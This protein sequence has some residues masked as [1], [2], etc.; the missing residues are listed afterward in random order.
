MNQPAAEPRPAGP[1]EEHPA[2]ARW[3]TYAASAITV[4]LAAAALLGW[5]IDSPTLRSLIAGLWQM[6]PFTAACLII[7]G[8]ALGAIHYGVWRAGEG[9]SWVLLAGQVMALVVAVVGAVMLAEYIFGADLLLDRIFFPTAIQSTARFHPGRSSAASSVAFIFAGVSLFLLGQSGTRARQAAQLTILPSGLIGF[10]GGVGYLFGSQEFTELTGRTPLSLNTAFALIFLAVGVLATFPHVGVMAVMTAQD[11]GGRL[12]RRLVPVAIGVPIILQWLMER[13]IS[14][15][16]YSVTYGIALV[17]A[18]LVIVFTAVVWRI[19]YAL[20]RVDRVRTAFEVERARLLEDEHR[21]REEEREYRELAESRARREAALR[22]ELEEVTESRARLVRGFSHDLKNPLGA[23]DGHA[24]LLESGIFGALEP[25]QQESVQRIRGALHAALELIDDLV[26][27]AR[28]EAGQLTIELAPIDPRSL[29]AEVAEEHR[30]HA[31][32]SGLGFEVEVPEVLPSIVSDASRVRQILGNLLSNAIK[33][34]PAGGRVT[35][36]VASC[37]TG[38]G[39]ARGRWLCL[40]VRDTGPGIPKEKQHKLFQEFVRLATRGEPGVGLGLAISQRIARLLGGELT[41]ESESGQGSTF[42]LWLPLAS[43][44]AGVG[45]RDG[46]EPEA[47]EGE[48]FHQLALE[49][50]RLQ[51]IVEHIPVGVTLAEAPSGRIVLTNPALEQILRRPA[52]ISPNVAAYGERPGYHADGRRYEAEEWPLARALLHG[53]QVR[54]EECHYRLGDGTMT[55]IRI[56]AAPIRDLSGEIVGAVESIVDF[57]AE[58]R[59]VEEQRFLSEAS[60]ILGSSLDTQTMLAG[61]AQ[62]AVKS[63]AEVC[64]I[65]LRDEA[66]GTLRLGAAA[67]RDPALAPLIARLREHPAGHANQE[68]SDAL[69]AGRPRLVA[70]V[71]DDWLSSAAVDE[72]Q[73]QLYREF[74]AKSM[75]LAPLIARGRSLGT[76]TFVRNSPGTHYTEDDLALFAEAS[77]RAA[78]AIDNARLYEAALVASQTKS[79]FLAVMSHELR[80]PLN[81]IVGY[82]DLLLLG[83]PKPLP[84]EDREAVYRITASA[85]RLKEQIDEIL[86][87]SRIEADREEVHLEEVEIGALVREVAGAVAP[88]IREKGLSLA[89]VTPEQ[90]TRI[91]TDPGELRQ[92][93]RNILSNAIKFTSRGEIRVEAAR[94]GDD[95]VIQI[96]DTGIGIAPEFRERVF[97]P[98]WQVERGMTRE[99]SGTGLGLSVSRRLARMLGGDITF[100]SEPG[101]GTTFMVR[102]PGI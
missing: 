56:D 102:L 50:A 24:A 20:S 60:A 51:V 85:Q 5:I 68:I 59:A 46:G 101:K 6:T 38:P 62:A 37:E 29:A 35:L 26:E 45:G 69:E 48:L 32:T 3:V 65:Y 49:R 84:E 76:A 73:F 1:A 40:A 95:V 64:V 57:T 90:A 87:F 30:A 72:A 88:I 31:E 27:L 22:Q 71:T 17:V 21:L 41:V 86:T 75:I 7:C 10:A 92:I 2:L 55:W 80:T 42:T 53:E 19:S 54:G 81:A 33:Y 47:S 36:S 66:N 18:A 25:K 89:C 11:M 70:E 74:N 77:R 9:V 93:L 97:E 44:A 83:V 8:V 13:G 15:G 52:L 39:Q 79:D 99:V 96:R 23:A 4:L 14:L 63:E 28:S 12:A 61:L 100:E 43:T 82:A 94:A 98:F 78:L 58:R 67:Y 34:T 91:K 16:L